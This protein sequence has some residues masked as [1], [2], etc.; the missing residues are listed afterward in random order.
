MVKKKSIF[1]YGIV[2]LFLCMGLLAM[3]AD[4]MYA[5]LT[6]ADAARNH[7]TIGGSSIELV[8]NFDPAQTVSPGKPIFKAVKV[9]N[10]GPNECYIRVK[11]VFADSD[12]ERYC[13]V[14]WNSVSWNYGT[15]G[16][17]YY[18]KPLAK[19]EE[20]DALFTVVNTS[21]S[22]SQ[23]LLDLFEMI[24]YAES[25]QA[26]GFSEYGS[27]WSHYHTNRT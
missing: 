21:S 12:V 18:V 4:R 23:T 17:W 3:A 15:D 26:Q 16:Y 14:D 2:L 1:R 19:G 7:F 25:C 24:V 5:Y 10:E 22:I 6:A 8:E 27:A 11:A 13:T 20:T 9:K